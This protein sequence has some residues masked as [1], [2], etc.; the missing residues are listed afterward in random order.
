MAMLRQRVIAGRANFEP[1][2][3]VCSPAE[4]YYAP[5]LDRLERECDWLQITLIYT[6]A[7]APHSPRPLK[8]IGPDDL[9][10]ALPGMHVY[11]CGPT[12]FVSRPA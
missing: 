2:Y 7:T 5:E 8:R 6:R 4:V 12:G 9:T 10:P 3:S 1:I 11:V